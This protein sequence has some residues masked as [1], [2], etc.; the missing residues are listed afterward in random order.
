MPVLLRSVLGEP[1]RLAQTPQL[2]ANS[3]KRTAAG[4][5][6]SSARLRRAG[7]ARLRL[8]RA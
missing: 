8:A 5:T 7:A 1:G 2:P 4:P 3:A 6:L